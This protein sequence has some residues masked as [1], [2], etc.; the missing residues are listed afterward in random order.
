MRKSPAGRQVRHLDTQGLGGRG[1]LGSRA[2]Q[3]GG[4]AAVGRPR[5][6][7]RCAGPGVESARRAHR[8]TAAAR[9]YVQRS[10]RPIGP[11]CNLPKHV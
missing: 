8:P 11:Y 4:R 3:C 5:T 6:V 9:A 10:W 2:L 1:R 7:P